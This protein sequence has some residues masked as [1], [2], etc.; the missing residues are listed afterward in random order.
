MRKLIEEMTREEWE[1]HILRFFGL[2]EALRSDASL[3]HMR[4]ELVQAL[5]KWS[6]RPGRGMEDDSIFIAW[7]FVD[8]VIAYTWAR[9]GKN[10]W[11]IPWARNSDEA[12]VFGEPIPV[13]KVELFEPVTESLRSNVQSRSFNEMVA[14]QQFQLLESTEAK[15][16]RVRAVGITADVVNG[17]RRRYPRAVLA[18][19]IEELNSHLNESNGQGRLIATGEVEHPSDKGRR[20]SLL[21]VVIKWDA[22]SL[23][24]EGKV[25]LEGVILPTSK[26]KDIAVL[27]ENGVPVGV[28]MRGYGSAEMLKESGLTV[29]EVTQLKIKGFDLVMEASDPNGKLL[30]SQQEEKKTMTLEE[31]LALL[32]EKPE[33]LETLM[34]ALDLASQKS[35]TEALEKMKGLEVKAADGEKARQELEERKAQEARDAAIAEVTKDL[36]YS[37]AMNKMFIESVKNSPAK[38]PE[39]I[40]AF[41]NGKREEY[42]QIA[43]TVKLAGMGK[44]AAKSGG[45][46]V[47]GPVYESE[48]G[49][50]EFTR[51]AFEINESLVRSTDIVKRDLAKDESKAAKFAERVLK[52]YDD[53][54]ERFLIAEAR[55]FAEAETTSDLNLPYSVART[56]IEQVFP[57]LVAANIY[58]FGVAAQSPERL[59]FEQYSGESGSAPAVV[60]EDVTGDHGVWVQLANKRVRPT[61]VVLTNSAGSTTYTEGTDYVMDYG[62]GKILTLAAGTTTDGQALKIDYTYDAMRKGEMAAIERGKQVLSYKTLEIAADRLA[63]QI[64][65][66][67]VVFSRSQLGYDAVGRTLNGLIRQIRQK[68]EKDLHYLALASALQQADNSGGTFTVASDAISVLVKYIGVAKVK[69]SNRFYQPTFALMSDTTADLLSNWDGF[70]RNGFPNAVLN[71]AGF[72]GGLKGLPVFSTPVFPDSHVLVANREIVQHRVFQAMTLKGPYPTYDS[73]KLVSA[74]QYFVE[75]YNGSD[76]PVVEKAA[77]VKIA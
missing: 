70:T 49:Q 20:A 43:A 40:K 61:T 37:D 7:T 8:R 28:S 15:G 45:V 63:T 4:D 56:I 47:V 35:L 27:V 24:T 32:K 54:Y 69:V 13:N 6:G 2:N 67:A 26:G 25:L 76:S 44:P 68:I 73:G 34:K 19:A 22:A 31:M 16:W 39:E 53:K 42:D 72:A 64:S 11:E 36:K 48:T 58:D 46:V 38:T 65:S 41:A 3:E 59:Y 17:N 5:R 30:E 23:N 55:M 12:I 21:E 66:E 60:D 75:E 29:Q 52:L 10:V 1:A 33:M 18:K 51:A 50:K 77:Y 57:E 71:A 9:D 14:L 62:N 74:D